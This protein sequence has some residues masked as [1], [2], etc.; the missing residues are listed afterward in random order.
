MAVIRVASPVIGVAVQFLFIRL[1]GVELYGRAAVL[2]SLVGLLGAVMASGMAATLTRELTASPERRGEVLGSALGIVAVGAIAAGVVALAAGPP[3]LKAVGVGASTGVALAVVVAAAAS[4]ALVVAAGAARGVEQLT[5][6]TLGEVLLMPLGTAVLLAVLWVL[7]VHV[8]LGAAVGVRAAAA[9]VAAAAILGVVLRTQRLRPARPV[10]ATMGELVVR[11][12]PIL[13]NQ[14][15]LQVASGAALW[16]LGRTTTGTDVTSYSL[17]QRLAVFVAIPGAITQF[18]TAAPL[19][20]AARA[21]EV[22]AVERQVRR[23]VLASTAVGLV[24]ATGALVVRAPLVRFLADGESLP[25]GGALALLVGAQIVGLASGPC[26]YALIMAGRERITV[27]A[28]LAGMLTTVVAMAP[29]V[30]AWGVTGAAL[31]TALGVGVTNVANLVLAR[32]ALGLRTWVPVGG[33]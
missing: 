1:L 15:V 33:R 22:V 32:Q 26:G 28:T 30:S 16:W 19:A 3:I 5:V 6:G 13:A 29:S 7:D 24:L 9:G 25:N 10:R 23:I 12:A 18:L 8:L 31:A 4:A 17:A 11:S 21:G 27:L 2:F 20:R 14:L